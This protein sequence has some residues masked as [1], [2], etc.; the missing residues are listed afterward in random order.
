M[1]INTNTVE[2]F[3][4]ELTKKEIE[5][6]QHGKTIRQSNHGRLFEIYSEHH[7]S[8]DEEEEE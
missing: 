4:I 3:V 2:R 7:I 1:I 6:L 5:N 8:K